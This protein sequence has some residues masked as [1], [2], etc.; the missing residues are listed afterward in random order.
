MRVRARI[1]DAPVRVANK[2][3]ITSENGNP[4]FNANAFRELAAAD[5]ERARGA[6]AR[7]EDRLQRIAA[8]AAAHRY[9]A[10]A[11]KRAHEQRSQ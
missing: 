5:E 7:L 10:E 6:A 2:G 4:S 11:T 9:R 1:L 8:L 3:R